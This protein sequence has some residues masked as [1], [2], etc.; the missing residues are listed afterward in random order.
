MTGALRTAL[1]ALALLAGCGPASDVPP[2]APV[3]QHAP[4]VRQAP[5]LQ[6]ASSAAARDAEADSLAA[7][8]VRLAQLPPEARDTLQRI[9]SGGPFA[10]ERDGSVFGNREGLLPKRPRGYYTEYTV[11]TPGARDR[12]ARR[13]VAGQGATGNPATGGE[14]W[15]TADHYNS[16]RRIRE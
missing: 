9:R 6:S 8:E 5:T 16:F 15:Y 7:D 1:A 12:G 13:I 3:A 11:R 4:A 2:P 14:Y 10:Y